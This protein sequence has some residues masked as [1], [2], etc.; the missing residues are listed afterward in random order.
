MLSNAQYIFTSER[1]LSVRIQNVNLFGKLR[2]TEASHN[3][4]Q[5]WEI[6]NL[7]EGVKYIC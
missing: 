2:I 3:E 4:R 5:Q 6:K 1:I 7:Q